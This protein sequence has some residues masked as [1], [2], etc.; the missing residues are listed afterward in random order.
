MSKRSTTPSK[1]K[2][3]PDPTVA[4][5][6]RY[7]RSFAEFVHA[8]RSVISSK[9]LAAASDINPAQVR[10]DLAYFGQFG[11][12]G[13]GYD[14]KTLDAK[15]REIL[16]LH[17]V[18]RIALI[19]AGNL[20]TALLQYGGFSKAGFKI[21]AAFDVDPSKVGWELEGVRIWA[22][23]AIR[24]VVREKKIEIGV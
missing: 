16:G 23:P 3:I 24:Q 10:K 1:K 8:N 13:I 12:R 4:R 20:G 6:P 19:G 9:E 14:V 15:M 21:E 18:W 2:S 17:K 22:T 5:L 11:Q 7:L